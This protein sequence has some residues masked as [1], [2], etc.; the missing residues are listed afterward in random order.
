MLLKVTVTV[1]AVLS[2][3]PTEKKIKAWS[4]KGMPRK[5]KK[6]KQASKRQNTSHSQSTQSSSDSDNNKNRS[7]DPQGRSSSDHSETAKP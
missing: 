7:S 4:D 2:W 1:T 3:K 5:K 6:K